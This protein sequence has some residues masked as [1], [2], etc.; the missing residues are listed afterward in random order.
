[1][2]K[3]KLELAVLL[4]LIISTS[5]FGNALAA[6]AAADHQGDD[7]PDKVHPVPDA[8]TKPTRIDDGNNNNDNSN[9]DNSNNH[10]DSKVKEINK[11]FRSGSNNDNVIPRMNFEVVNGTNS[12]TTTTTA[13]VTIS[14]CDGIVPGPCLDKTTGQIIP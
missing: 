14:I 1:M 12:T 4:A 2:R 5:V 9:N 8:G 11:L 7:K 10:H 6:Y 13:T 3:M